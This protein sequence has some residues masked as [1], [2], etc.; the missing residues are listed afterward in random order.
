MSGISVGHII[1]VPE[2]ITNF[3][4]VLYKENNASRFSKPLQLLKSKVMFSKDR[5]VFRAKSIIPPVYELDL[6]LSRE[7]T[8]FAEPYSEPNDHVS[9]LVLIQSEL[10]SK[11]IVPLY[12]SNSFAF[13]KVATGLLAEP[14]FASDPW[15][16]YVLM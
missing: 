13:V 4:P 14:L 3:A 15:P 10:T 16:T 5:V 1:F 11:Y 2:P 7:S 8:I 9:V 6:K 12:A